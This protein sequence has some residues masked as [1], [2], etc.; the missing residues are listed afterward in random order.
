M[1]EA[2]ERK[3]N[4]RNRF[5]YYNLLQTYS[6]HFL[7]E[8]QKEFVEYLYLRRNNYVHNAGKADIKLK[9]KLDKTPVPINE[10]MLSTEA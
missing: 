2:I 10:I 6:I 4:L 1:Y 7:S 5:D 3:L 9:A 8:D